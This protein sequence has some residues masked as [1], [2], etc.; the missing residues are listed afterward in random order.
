MGREV[1]MVPKDWRHPKSANGAYIPMYESFP[2][3]EEEIE[4][5][6]KDGW[7]QNTPPHYGLNCMPKFPD[8]EC[9]HFQMYETCSEGTPISPP[10][11]TPEALA[12]WLVDNKASAFAGHTATYEQWLA[13]INRGW[14]ISVVMSNGE[15]MTGVASSL[16]GFDS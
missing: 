16:R 14:A 15:F 3:S 11:E 6:L 13:T 9:T 12:Q 7:L 5:G 2:F 10:M 4:N 8:S 1:R